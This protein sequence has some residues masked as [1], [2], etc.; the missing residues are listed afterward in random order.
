MLNWIQK[1]G[2]VPKHYVLIAMRH[3]G[4]P[5]ETGRFWE[6][7]ELYY[8][9]D[10]GECVLFLAWKGLGSCKPNGMILRRGKFKLDRKDSRFWDWAFSGK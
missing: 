1:V 3:R 2:T 8:D 4:D 9:P 6:R 10:K 7:Y 5:V